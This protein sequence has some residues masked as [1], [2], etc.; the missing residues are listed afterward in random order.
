MKAAVPAGPATLSRLVAWTFHSISPTGKKF[1]STVQELNGVEDSRMVVQST[2]VGCF[3]E[4]LTRIGLLPSELTRSQLSV[5]GFV[6]STAVPIGL[7]QYA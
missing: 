1:P 5:I 2:S 3:Q 6:P 4:R 7:R